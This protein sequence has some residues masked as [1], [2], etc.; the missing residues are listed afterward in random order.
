VSAPGAQ[1]ESEGG[2][3]GEPT[4]EQL[5]AAYEEELSRISAT[6]MIAQVSVSL[7]NVGAYRLAPAQTG[8]DAPAQSGR[9]LEQARD[10]IDA[11]R[12]LLEILE[13][14]IPANELRPLRDALSRLQMTY[15]HEM[16]AAPGAQ[17][18][19]SASA[20]DPTPPAD[21]QPAAGGQASK[22][23]DTQQ[24]PEAQEPSRGPGPAEASGRLW[25]P[26]R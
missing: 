14:R 15:A 11:V 5:R 2:P 8:A 16:A 19:A 7:L 26:G 13:R 6:D 21:Q 12:A 23:A 9:D 20:P 3:G 17:A 25:V 1:A 24:D 22:P 18:G 10:A 4:E